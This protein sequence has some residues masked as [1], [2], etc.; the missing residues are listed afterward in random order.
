MFILRA[1][2]VT[3]RHFLE[4][5]AFRS[6]LLDQ[7]S[8]PLVHPVVVYFN[9]CFLLKIKEAATPSLSGLLRQL[10]QM[11]GFESTAGLELFCLFQ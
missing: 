2:K 8:L 4:R 6:K 7:S 11:A 3:K 9:L 10:L 5:L 1:L